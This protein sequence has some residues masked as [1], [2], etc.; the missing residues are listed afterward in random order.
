PTSRQF[1]SPPAPVVAFLLPPPFPRYLR[2]HAAPPVPGRA[3]P[4]HAVFAIVAQLR[5]R[6]LRS[7]GGRSLPFGVRAPDSTAGA[8]S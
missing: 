8:H 2:F 4:P 6:L 1:L 5:S 3:A 7:L